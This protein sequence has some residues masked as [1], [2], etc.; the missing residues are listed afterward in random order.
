MENFF[1]NKI[2]NIKFLSEQDIEWKKFL[3]EQDTEYKISFRT[4][5]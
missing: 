4:R 2:L 5:Y 1:Q 3:S